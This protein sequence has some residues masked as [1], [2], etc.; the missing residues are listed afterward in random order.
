[1][2]DLRGSAAEHHGLAWY[3]REGRQITHDQWIELRLDV[4]G[5]GNDYARIA[6]DYVG[7]V[8]VSTVWLGLDHRHLITE[9]SRPLVFETMIFGGPLG[10]E[11]WRY[12]T[13]EEA[14]AG[15]AAALELVRGAT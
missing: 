13:E 4:T 6:L 9:G 1:M 8:N 11:M 10:G 12:S 5:D 15:H 14:L 3:D 2:S 7:E